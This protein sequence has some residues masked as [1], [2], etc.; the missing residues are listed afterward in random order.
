MLPPDLSR[1][2]FARRLGGH[3]TDHGRGLAIDRERNILV[4]GNS[5]SA[6]WPARNSLQWRR[7]GADDA[8]VVKLQRQP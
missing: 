3:G 5:Q 4:T 2:G 6:D 1:I 8:I 7:L